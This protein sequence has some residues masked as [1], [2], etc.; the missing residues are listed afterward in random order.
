MD[1]GTCYLQPAIL[2]KGNHTNLIGDFGQ[3]P[4]LAENEGHI[5]LT[6]NGARENVDCDSHIDALLLGGV[7]QILSI[8]EGDG[9]FCYGL[10][11]HGSSFA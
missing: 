2:L 9:A 3:V 5:A 10:L 11:G 8:E 6:A 1:Q 4:I 7:K